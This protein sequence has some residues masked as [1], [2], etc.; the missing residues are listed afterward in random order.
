MRWSKINSLLKQMN[1]FSEINLNEASIPFVGNYS[2]T[3]S[4]PKALG[5]IHLVQNIRK[6]MTNTQSSHA[7]SLKPKIYEPYASFIS[8]SMHISDT[9]QFNELYCN[10]LIKHKYKH[11]T[12][13]V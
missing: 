3:L 4:I 13:E 8:I 6:N 2:N 5:S 9:H 10:I 7:V 12:I 11:P 1:L